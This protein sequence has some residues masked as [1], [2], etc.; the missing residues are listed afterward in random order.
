MAMVLESFDVLLG[1]A[2]ALL[3]AFGAYLM[4]VKDGYLRIKERL[5]RKESIALGPYAVPASWVTSGSPVF[6]SN[7]FGQSQDRSTSSGLWECTGPAQF[8]WHYG[9]DETI[10]ILEGSAD[11]EYLGRRFTLRAGDCTDFAAGTTSNWTVS[12]RVKR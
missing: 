12:E 10:Y 6:R 8:T 3:A 7:T 11:V 2:A 4:R 9:T 1:V 5:G